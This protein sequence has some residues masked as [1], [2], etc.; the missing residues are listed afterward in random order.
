MGY[1]FQELYLN[2]PSKLIALTFSTIITIILIPLAYGIIWFEQDNNNRTLINQLVASLMWWILIWFVFIQPETFFFFAFGPINVSG[3]CTIHT[4]TRNVVIIQGLLMQ[5][6]IVLGRYIFIFHLKN[7]TALQDDFWKFFINLWSAVTSVLSQYIFYWTPGKSPIH[8][9]ICLGEDPDITNEQGIKPNT[10]MTAIG[11]S[12]IV[13]FLIIRIRTFIYKKKENYKISS[14]SGYNLFSFS[15]TGLGI[16]LIGIIYL[17]F[18][19]IKSNVIKYVG[20][21]FHMVYVLYI[22]APVIAFAIVIW[23]YYSGC[24]SL[25]SKVHAHFLSYFQ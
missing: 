8:Y 22:Y 7:P 24:P 11:I 14:R 6:S 18:Q 1:E 20:F 12:S 10:S 17:I 16:F 2:N 23:T 19:L 3:F 5:N 13:L 4:Y 21:N 9:H 25:R 15:A